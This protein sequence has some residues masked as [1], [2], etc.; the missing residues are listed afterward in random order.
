MSTARITLPL[1]RRL[2]C[3]ERQ[4]RDISIGISLISDRPR[5]APFL[6]GQEKRPAGITPPAFSCNCRLGRSGSAAIAQ[7]LTVTSLR[8]S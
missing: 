5:M 1:F 4:A 7:S 8:K 3:P 6:F 2:D